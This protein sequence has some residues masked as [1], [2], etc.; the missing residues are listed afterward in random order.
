ME[1]PSRDPAGPL[2]VGVGVSPDRGVG[3]PCHTLFTGRTM[4][5]FM[6]WCL[7]FRFGKAGRWMIDKLVERIALIVAAKV[8]EELIERL[9][10]ISDLI[11]ALIPDIV[12]RIVDEIGQRLPFPFGK[13]K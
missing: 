5:R 12:E 3:V 6:L 11:S 2:L 13:L 1:R 9:P 7:R 4:P 10:D 8:A